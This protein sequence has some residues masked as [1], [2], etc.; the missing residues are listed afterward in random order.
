[1][2]INILDFTVAFYPDLLN[3]CTAS[4][5]SGKARNFAATTGIPESVLKGVEVPEREILIPSDKYPFC[6][7]RDV[8]G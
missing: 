8:R 2:R 1:M 7:R 3:K 6:A 5:R 4:G